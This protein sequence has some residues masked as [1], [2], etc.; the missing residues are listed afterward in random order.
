MFR[1]VI[2]TITFFFFFI[3][4]NLMQILIFIL[5]FKYNFSVEMMYSSLSSVFLN[6]IIIVINIITVIILLSLLSVRY[7]VYSISNGAGI[8]AT[9]L[10]IIDEMDIS[11]SSSRSDIEIRKRWENIQ[12][13]GRIKRYLLKITNNDHSCLINLRSII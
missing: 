12:S 7:F 2:F 6:F 11:G 8:S 3:W 4:C 1:N 10:L 9:G 13:D 5:A